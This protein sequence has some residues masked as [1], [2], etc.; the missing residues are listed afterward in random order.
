MRTHNK[1]II[2]DLIEITNYLE[3]KKDKLTRSR[4]FYV[5]PEFWNL[6]AIFQ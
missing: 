1:D 2:I 4:V 3:E 5:I 6:L